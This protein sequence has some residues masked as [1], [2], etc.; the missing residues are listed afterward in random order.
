MTNSGCLPIFPEHSDRAGGESTESP[1]FQEEVTIMDDVSG[2]NQV[3]CPGVFRELFETGSAE[4]DVF[5]LLISIAHPCGEIDVFESTMSCDHEVQQVVMAAIRS[6]K[7]HITFL[8]ACLKNSDDNIR[9]LA[10]LCLAIA[11]PAAEP[12]VDDLIDAV[13]DTDVQTSLGASRALSCIGDPAGFRLLVRASDEKDK[14]AAD[15]ILKL[16]A[17]GYLAF[18]K[19]A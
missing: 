12:V 15:A 10:A 14:I 8:S 4:R 7:E 6:A 2:R 5:S 17:E 18:I 13:L 1:Q 19:E 11:G 3:E 16:L 9:A